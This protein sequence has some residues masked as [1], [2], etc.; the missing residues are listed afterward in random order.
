VHEVEIRASATEGECLALARKRLS[1]ESAAYAERMVGTWT[2]AVYGGMAPVPATVEALC[3]EF[4][5]ALARGA[6]ARGGPAK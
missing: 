4:A 3:G 1:S 2:A 5:G 6:L